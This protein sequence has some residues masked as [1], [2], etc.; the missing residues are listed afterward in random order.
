[1]N[2][3]AAAVLASLSLLQTPALAQNDRR[4]QLRLAV[5]DETNSPVPNAIV[6]IYTMYGPRTVNADEK[7]VVVVA[8]LP[9][10]LTQVWA[11]TP[12]ALSGAEATKLQ[13]G[14]NRQ[15]L[16]LHTMRRAADSSESGS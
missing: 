8:D 2:V 11:R 10:E 9:A 7:G 12:G 4:A 15:T 3:I 5:V 16:T 14:E 6:T 1:M 13:T